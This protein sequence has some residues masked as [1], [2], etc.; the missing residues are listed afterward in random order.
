MV[1]LHHE[2]QINSYYIVKMVIGIVAAIETWG[3]E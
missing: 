1:I 3:Y 2:I